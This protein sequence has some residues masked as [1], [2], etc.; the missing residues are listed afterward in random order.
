[1]ESTVKMS[2]QRA[3]IELEGELTIEQA[4]ELKSLLLQGLE[5]AETLSLHLEKV[6]EADLSC[7]QMLCSTC[8]SCGEEKKELILQV[9]GSEVFKQL[10]EDAG[11]GRTERCPLNQNA[12]CIWKG[13]KTSWEN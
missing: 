1:M 12:N 2:D 6:T 3:E 8:K 7:L 9:G 11:Y 4:E 13:G 10:V 5:Q